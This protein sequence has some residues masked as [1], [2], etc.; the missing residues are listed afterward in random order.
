MKENTM[1][2]DGAVRI[3]FMKRLKGKE[4][5]EGCLTVYGD[6]KKVKKAIFGALAK[7]FTVRTEGKV[8]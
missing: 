1:K 6:L 8:G 5:Y 4:S 7:D 3:V 2:W